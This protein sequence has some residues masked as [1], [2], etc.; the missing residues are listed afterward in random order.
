MTIVSGGTHS[1]RVFVSPANHARHTSARALR[2]SSFGV[3]APMPGVFLCGAVGAHF[4]HKLSAH[5][6]RRIIAIIIFSIG[7]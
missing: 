4:S 6:L 2:S 3:D 1:S 5:G 7:L